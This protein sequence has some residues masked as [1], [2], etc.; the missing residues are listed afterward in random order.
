M[1]VTNRTNEKEFLIVGKLDLCQCPGFRGICR[2][3]LEKIQRR[4]STQ[5]CGFIQYPVNPDGGIGF[6]YGD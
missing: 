2:I 3:P 6:P 1:I 5:P 4:F